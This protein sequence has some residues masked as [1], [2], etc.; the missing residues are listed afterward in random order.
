MLG[1]DF[2][3]GALG[4]EGVWGEGSG[5][6][7][8]DGDGEDGC[9]AGAVE[10]DVFVFVWGFVRRLIWRLLVKG[11]RRTFD[12]DGWRVAAGL[13]DAAEEDGDVTGVVSVSCCFRIPLYFRWHSMTYVMSH[14]LNIGE[15]YEM[16]SEK[17]HLIHFR[18]SRVDIS[19]SAPIRC[20]HDANESY[21]HPNDSY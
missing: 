5:D 3:E 15:F 17:Y 10:G 14:C 21:F 20:F 1:L 16:L 8:G 13:H 4:G 7:G 2:A 11:D 18:E 12:F 19:R 6:G 9:E